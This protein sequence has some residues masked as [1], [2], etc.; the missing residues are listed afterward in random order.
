MYIRLFPLVIV[1]VG[2]LFLATNLGL[3]PASEVRALVTT[4]WPLVPIVIGL[5]LLGA[6]SRRHRQ[7]AKHSR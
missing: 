5:S 1:A 4:W 2:A 3:V 6:R 7:E